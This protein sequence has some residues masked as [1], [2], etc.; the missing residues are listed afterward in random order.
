MSVILNTLNKMSMILM[1][2]P[3]TGDTSK[4]WLWV[5]IAAVVVVVAVVFILLSRKN[6]DDEE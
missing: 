6:K 5:T 2:S 3:S 1:N 4:P